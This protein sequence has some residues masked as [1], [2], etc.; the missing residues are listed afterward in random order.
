MKKVLTLFAAVALG[1]SM[2]SA[3]NP[4]SSLIFSGANGAKLATGDSLAFN[5]LTEFTVEAWVNYAN[6]GGGYIMSTESNEKCDRS[7]NN[8]TACGWVLKA[9]SNRVLLSIGNG[10][11]A[12]VKMATDV[13]LG[14]WFHVAASYKETRTLQDTTAQT[15]I[16]LNGVPSD[17]LEL[18]NPMNLS[19]KKMV[20]GDGT[21]WFPRAF[22]GK[23]A[24]VR[25][26]N[27]VRTKDQIASNFGLG[28][29]SGTETGL[30]ANWKMNEKTGDVIAD[31]KGKYNFT[32]PALISWTKPELTDM[33]GPNTSLIFSGNAGSEIGFAQNAAF[34]D[35]TAFTVESWVNFSDLNGGYVLCTESGANGASGW[36]LK[37]EN[38]RLI[39]SIGN[40]AWTAAVAN[41]PVNLGV[42]YHVAATY[43]PTQVKLYINGELEATKDLATPMKFSLKGMKFGEGTEWTNRKFR[44]KMADVRF[45]NVV[46]T[47]EE[48]AAKI[49][50]GS[51]VGT[52]TGLVGNWKMNEGTGNAVADIK[53]TYNQTI[54]SN[55]LQWNKVEQAPMTKSLQFN[56]ANGAVLT[57]GTSPLF[58]SPKEFT[59]EANVN[60]AN[61]D[62]GYLLSTESGE[63]SASGWV[64]KAENGKL[65]LSIGNGNWSAVKTLANVPC[66]KWM[67]VAATY[68]E[69]GTTT[70]ETVIYIDG[71]A[72]DTL[73]LNERMRLSSKGLTIGDGSAWPGR[74]FRGRMADVRY[75][76][77]ARTFE[78]IN[79][80]KALGALTGWEAGLVSNWKMNEGTG[81][82]VADIKGQFTCAKPSVVAWTPY[83][84]AEVAP[85]TTLQFVGKNDVAGGYIN[86][87][88]N[89]AFTD[90]TAFTTEAWLKFSDLGGGYIMSTESNPNNVST[91][92]VLKAEGGKMILSIGNGAWTA[93]VATT[94]IFLNQWFHVA[95]TYTPTQ[96]KLY[97]N[98]VLEATKDLATPMNISTKPLY[99]GE[100]TEWGN[101]RFKGEMADVRFWNVVRTAEEIAASKA[102]GSLAGTEAGLIG[103]WKMNEGQ[104]LNVADASGKYNATIVLGDDK[105]IWHGDI[106][107]AIQKANGDSKEVDVFVNGNELKVVNNAKVAMTVSV[108]DIAGMK[109]LTF[110]LEAGATFEKEM[111][112]LNGVY[113]LNCISAKGE[114]LTKKVLFN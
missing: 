10:G 60:F 65:I 3:A 67:H 46:R 23:L 91:G 1:F 71:V 97:I 36:V 66:G 34:T 64:L 28:A 5:G 47:P 105:F 108:Y 63:N 9:E 85:R 111:S 2:A 102:A 81:D 87:G 55:I 53:G 82:V 39:M 15:I 83:A 30:V 35:L 7:P 104:G 107:T 31:V 99:I 20:I 32:K 52:E 98:G 70:A 18:A 42:W 112:S 29:L 49:I 72:Q 26:W 110:A 96:T 58:T 94:P 8:A 100:G 37:A 103:N 56:G 57:C 54:D 19:H 16:Y 69:T 6:L 41:T 90:L 12:A 86:C 75:W 78:Q 27:V 74:Y 95:A 59:V 106:M 11:W 50:P 80:S 77:V 113:F 13:K 48:I 101:R 24:D 45:W 43:T 109:V 44:G 68:K 79:A 92:W 4:T 17:T 88:V 76:S 114:K 51:L 61:L 73:T 84:F 38:G 62:G 22:N 25:F 14:Q 33:L 89:T 40:G 21:E 93:A